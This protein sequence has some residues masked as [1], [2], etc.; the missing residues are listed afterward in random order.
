[1]KKRIIVGLVAVAA[2]AGGLPYV[3]G[4]VAESQTKQSVADFNL[5]SQSLY[6]QVEIVKYE[7]GYNSTYAEYKW[8]TNPELQQELAISEI[9]LSCDGTHNMLSFDYSCVLKN[10][11]PQDEQIRAVFKGKEPLIVEG[12]IGLTGDET[13]LMTINPF[14]IITPSNVR[15]TSDGGR[16]S[17]SANASMS[18][19]KVEGTFSPVTV[20]DTSGGE[21]RISE[22]TLT[23]DGGMLEKK[24]FL[25]D[26]VVN[27]NDI[28][29]IA[30]MLDVP[31]VVNDVS[32]VSS[33][34]V[35]NGMYSGS[36]SFNIGQFTL[37]AA[38][39]KRTNTDVLVKDVSIGLSFADAP[40]APLAELSDYSSK[41]AEQASATGAVDPGMMGMDEEYL[42]AQVLALLKKDLAINLWVNS[43]INE[44]ALESHVNT[45]LT[46][47]I[48]AEFISELETGGALAGLK[49]LQMVDMDILVAIP[50]SVIQLSPEV[51]MMA[52]MSNRFVADD[53]GLTAKLV[54]QDGAITLNG[55][56]TSI[57]ALM[58]N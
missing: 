14:E 20:V 54:L 27:V 5:Q 52:A 25:G 11:G 17:T 16:I 18:E 53:S 56:P 30:P 40:F 38:L 26:S 15:I 12:N 36:G 29:V 44:G 50:D 23:M 8:V 24:Y 6:G 2:V 10:M 19:L 34:Q 39:N 58:R 31:V 41:L 42:K 13:S 57:E 48:T 51:A 49:L 21:V 55:Q 33:G 28:T 45:R 9:V 37:P 7:R 1:M 3:T 32:M 47:D 43:D 46:K 22:S 35:D 4:Y